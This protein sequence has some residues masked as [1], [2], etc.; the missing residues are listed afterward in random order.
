[1]LLFS[2]ART[3]LH[4]RIRVQPVVDYSRGLGEQLRRTPPSDR[5]YRRRAGQLL[6]LTVERGDAMEEG[7]WEPKGFGLLQ[8][9]LLQR[10]APL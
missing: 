1:M 2:V 7:S 10:S 9:E 3:G 6:S 4:E 8:D 5:P